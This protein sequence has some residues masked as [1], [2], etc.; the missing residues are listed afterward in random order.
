MTAYVTP[1]PGQV[2][3]IPPWYS[4]QLPLTYELA[5]D[6]GKF[7]EIL[8]TSISKEISKEKKLIKLLTKGTLLPTGESKTILDEMP[9]DE[10]AKISIYNYFAEQLLYCGYI[11]NDKF[12]LIEK[13]VEG[14]EERNLIV[15]HSLYGRRINDTLSRIIAIMLRDIY[16]TDIAVNITDNGFVLVTE[17]G[18][19]ITN[20]DLNEVIGKMAGVDLQKLLKENIRNTEMMKR[21]FRHSAARAFMI[22]RNY[23]GIKISVRKQQINSQLI[24][25]AAE[26]LNPN[27]PIIKETYREILDDVMDLPRT[28]AMAK[29]L[30]SGEIKYK[31]IETEVPSP[32]SH[33]MITFGESDI[34]MMKDRRRH[35]KELYKQVMSKIN[36]MA[37]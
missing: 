15:F 8:T 7:R 22:L 36:K 25:K 34:I 20:K 23:N 17:S 37:K 5:I 3:T 29:M 21:R 27:F 9:I 13:T 1:A 24:L 26:Q 10:N 35:I 28:A 4:E 11:P 30:Y 2:P 12:L 31:I 33:N 32:F 16:E 18:V 14:E 6:I 19:K